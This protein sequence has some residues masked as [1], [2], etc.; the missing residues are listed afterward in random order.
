MLKVFV[1]SE[2]SIVLY[3]QHAEQYPN[4]FNYKKEQQL[5]TGRKLISHHWFSDE[6][7]SRHFTILFYCWKY[8]IY[9]Y[10]YVCIY[11]AVNA[12]K[13]TQSL[14][15]NKEMGYT[16]TILLNISTTVSMWYKINF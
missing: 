11:I 14:L 5:K 3:G 6:P 16:S 10:M 13:T 7:E 12:E 4:I 1:I 8:Y 9:I 2:I 15:H